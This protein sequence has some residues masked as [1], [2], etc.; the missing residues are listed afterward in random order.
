VDYTWNITVQV[1]E[2]PSSHTRL[3]EG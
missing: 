2:D 1:L 3:H